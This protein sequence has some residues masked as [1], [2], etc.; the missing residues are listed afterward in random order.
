MEKEQF[1]L[2]VAKL[3]K[4]HGMTQKELGE[5]LNITD[6]AISKWERGLSYPDIS[7]L[8]DLSKALDVTI[9]ELLDGKKSEADTLEV[10][11]VKR[12]IDYS[13]EISDEEM[14]RRKEKSKIIIVFCVVVLMLFA[15][16]ILNIVNYVKLT[17]E[18]RESA[19]I[20]NNEIIELYDSW[21]GE[22]NE[23]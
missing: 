21:E 8:D 3:R 6:K 18:K 11:E 5:K 20:N 4:E 9:V 23:Y 17:N 12:L 22:E 19:N 16:I 13:I 2:F 7:M 10:S 1:G 15:S 14:I